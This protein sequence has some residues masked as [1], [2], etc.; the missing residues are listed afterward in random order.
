MANSGH[1][2]GEALLSRHAM[3]ADSLARLQRLAAQRQKALVESVCR[4]EQFIFTLQT[5]SVISSLVMSR[6]NML[7]DKASRSCL[8]DW[9]NA[10][11][12]NE[13]L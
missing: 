10:S 9:I 4:L 1:P 3:L 6:I 13:R 5:S 2:E 7:L 11:I 8:L 12:R